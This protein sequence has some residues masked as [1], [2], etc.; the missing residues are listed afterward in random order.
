MPKIKFRK[1]TLTRL[2]VFCL[3]TSAL[4]VAGP[5]NAAVI[6]YPNGSN[7]TSPVVLTGNSTQ[8]QVL[9]GSATQSGPISESGG[10]FSLEKI[11]SGTLVFSGTNTYT[12]TTTISAGTLQIGSAT[13]LAPTSALAINGGTFDLH[14]F[15]LTVGAL[16]GSSGGSIILG[17]GTLTISS[18]ANTTLA[19]SISGIGSLAQAGTGVLTLTGNNTFESNLIISSGTVKVVADSNLGGLGF[20]GSHI[21][22]TGGTLQFGAGFSVSNL[23]VFNLDGPGGSIDTNGFDVTINSSLVGSGG[24]TKTGA[25]KLLL[26][27]NIVGY[28]GTTTISSGTLQIGDAMSTSVVFHDSIIDNG[29]LVLSPI[30]ILQYSVLAPISGSGTL[31]LLTGTLVL[32]QDDTRTGNT[33]ISQGAV[34]RTS[35]A[36]SSN[37][38]TDG[39]LIFSQGGTLTYSSVIS[40]AGGIIK[41]GPGKVILA[42]ANT[43]TGYTVINA[44]TLQ[45]GNGGT[46]GAISGSSTIFNN[47]V[48][49]INRSDTFALNNTMSGSGSIEYSGT[50][51]LVV[52]SLPAPTTVRSG[53]LQVN[54]LLGPQPL[55]MLDGSTL[56]APQHNRENTAIS[57]QGSVTFRNV[58]DVL[59]APITDGAGP[60]RLIVA[61]GT[62]TLAG[63]NS[64]SG[65]TTIQSGA[66]LSLGD[67]RS[68]TAGRVQGAIVN[69]GGLEV[70]T[71]LNAAFNNAVSGTGRFDKYGAGILT[72]TS[73]LT[74][75]GGTYFQTFTTG[76]GTLRLGT[77][78]SLP[79]GGALTFQ[80]AQPNGGTLDLNGHNQII[81][82]LS[83]VPPDNMTAPSV[84]ILTGGGTLTVGDTNDTVFAG[85]ISGTGT[86]VKTGSG[87]LTLAGTNPF[88]G[89]TL[90]T[91]GTLS[92]TPYQPVSAPSTVASLAASAIT[93]QSGGTL[94]GTGTVGSTIVA[95]GGTLAPGNS[96][97]TLTVNGNLTLASGANYSAEVSPTAAD[98][99]VVSGTASLNGTVVTSVA[100]G[101]Y[102][103]G[104]RYTILTATGG[105]SGAFAALSGI[106][107]YLKG[108][109]SYDAN[110]AYLTLSPNALAPQLT[111]G[112]PNQ[113]KLVSA[114][115]AAVTSG[116]VPGAGFQALYGLTG[117]A[118]NGALDQISGQVGPNTINAVGQG[119]LSF[120]TMMA[121]GGSGGGNFAPG[122]AYGGADA[123]HRAQL[124]AGETRVWGAAYGGHVGFSADATS[125]AA[126]LSSSNVGL[127]GGVD[128]A[129][130]EGFLAGVTV[131]LGRQNFS[132]GN[133]TGSSDDIMIGVYARKDVGPLYVTAALGYGS[134]HIET[135]RVVTVSGTDVLQSKQNADDYGGRIEAGWRMAL[136]DQYTLTPYFA[137]AAESFDSP[138]YMETALS[139]V[140]A[141]ALSYAS[142]S[143]TLGRTELGSWLSRDYETENGVM[144]ADLRAAWAHQLDDQPFTQ[145]SF[146]TLPGASFLVTGVRSASDTALLGASIQVQNRSGLFFG[147]KGETQLAVGTTILQ[148]MGNLGWRW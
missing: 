141:F 109:F 36:I 133:G 137:V 55:T 5:T 60:G 120:L 52:N 19:S 33:S 9:T 134:H 23:H 108:Q 95:S 26:A 144:T 77:G 37:I 38:A 22:L 59:N 57:L 117:P 97:G 20:G 40:G 76:A 83:Y 28:T 7:N 123:P 138:A 136:D 67:F 62:V 91:A 30:P 27:Q 106:P 81:G 73:A 146:Q 114:I 39:T 99:T 63:A 130:D 105:V 82:A 127:I 98:R 12:G 101:A 45:I 143:S 131:G 118:L 53:T 96:I 1:K 93:V 129:W 44:G 85:A 31:S 128:M 147:F 49:S 43:Y 75:T 125:G 112:T 42:N 116:G 41:E 69:N 78:G 51:T 34:L 80:A 8:L 126:S 79:T 89:N 15:N 124:G 16:S 140:S 148:G 24:L 135:L 17:T 50:G 74:H 94:A 21:V 6:D 11:G 121:Q 35:A 103:F 48:L 61:A 104:Q 3:G 115:D 14:N 111:S 87:T 92:V 58:G 84:S 122:S 32:T 132:S 119:S 46:T 54:N 2:A 71:E 56:V 145:A 110:N 142:H 139:G 102:A 4:T 47:A 65:G 25:G 18:A 29:N 13:S 90:V 66:V 10:Q 72:L 88:T 100:P 70:H 107:V 86:L 64:Y 68:V 113:Q